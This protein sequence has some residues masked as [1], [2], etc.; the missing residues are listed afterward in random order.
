MDSAFLL[1]ANVPMGQAGYIN[2]LYVNNPSARREALPLPTCDTVQI[3]RLYP[4]LRP[5]MFY[6]GRYTWTPLDTEKNCQQ[7]RYRLPNDF[8]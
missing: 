7:Q 4:R 3:R 1:L 8:K 6:L 2:D 5:S